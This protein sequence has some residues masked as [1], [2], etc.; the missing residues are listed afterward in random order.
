MVAKLFKLHYEYIKVALST[1]M[2]YKVNFITQ[3]FAMILNNSV[4]LV[5]WWIF[6]NKF[7]ML[8]GW[9]MEDVILL[10]SIV[11]ISYGLGGFFFGNRLNISHLIVNGKLDF[12]LT[13]PK[14]ILYHI[15]ISKSNF[16]DVGDVIFGVV[17]AIISLSLSQVPLF[18]VFSISSGIIFVAFAILVNSLAFYMGS[19]ESTSKHLF[20]G[21]LALS[22]YPMS[23]FKGA[24]KI[25]ILTLIPA[26]FI[27][28]I[29]ISLL[30]EFNLGWFLVTLGFASL[31]LFLSIKVFHRGL[32][33]YE[34]GNLLYVRT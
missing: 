33:K 17:L 27:S 15:L 20:F 2:E 19:A 5:F 4:W 29:P 21:T 25:I 31:I 16:Y 9:T 34:S 8:N 28:G 6:F 1:A 22:S 12:Y 30:K 26:G 23:I 11:T 14:N 18:L 7:Q 3:V 32:R 24:A 13:L 10:Y